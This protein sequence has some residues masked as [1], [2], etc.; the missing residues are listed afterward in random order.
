MNNKRQQPQKLIMTDDGIQYVNAVK[1]Y[2]PKDLDK[3]LKE[4][5]LRFRTYVD[6]WEENGLFRPERIA[7]FREI[8]KTV[9]NNNIKFFTER[10]K[11]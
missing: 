8:I 10:V 6:I 5:V 3:Y 2:F 1:W 4:N 9:E 7:N 11:V